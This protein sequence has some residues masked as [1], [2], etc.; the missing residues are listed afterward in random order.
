ML[1]WYLKCKGYQTVK[2][3]ADAFSRWGANVFEVPIPEFLKLLEQQLLAPFFVFQVYF[4]FTLYLLIILNLR[5]AVCHYGSWMNTG[6][7]IIITTTLIYNIA[8]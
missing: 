5:L 1:S 7:I 2:E 4:S 3:A 8:T 6:I